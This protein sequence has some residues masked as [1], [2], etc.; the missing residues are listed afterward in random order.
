MN[1][2]LKGILGV[3]QQKWWISSVPSENATFGTLTT[4]AFTAFTIFLFCSIYELL[5]GKHTIIDN[6]Q[7]W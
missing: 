7:R 3:S 1:G 2:S 4:C 5:V 6:S